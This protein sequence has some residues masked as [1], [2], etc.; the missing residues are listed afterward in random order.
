MV[1]QTS[2]LTYYKNFVFRDSDIDKI[3]KTVQRGQIKFIDQLELEMRNL[4]HNY[5]CYFGANQLITQKMDESVQATAKMLNE[6]KSCIECF[7][8]KHKVRKFFET[9]FWNFPEPWENIEKIWKF[10]EI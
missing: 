2:S 6:M 4:S 7:L 8:N 1:K 10:S 3:K 5:N 9:F